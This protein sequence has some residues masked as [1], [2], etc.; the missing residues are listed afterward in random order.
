MMIMMMMIVII[1]III[2]II[3]NSRGLFYDAAGVLEYIA[4]ITGE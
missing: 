4:S 3:I 2:I 1:I